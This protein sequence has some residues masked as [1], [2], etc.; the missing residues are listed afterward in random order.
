LAG[1]N[2]KGSVSALLESCF[3]AA[4]FRT[5]RYNSP[6]L[7]EARDAVR[8]DGLP[9]SRE[10]YAN[11]LAQVERVSK[12]RNLDATTFEI[13]TAAF[14]Y[15][16]STAQPPVD[17][18]IVE[19]GMGGARDATNVMPDEIIL[20]SG[21]TSVGLDHTDR[22][23]STIGE[24]AREKASIVVSGAVLVTSPNLHPEATGVARAI[25]NERHAH[26]IQA[27]PSAMLAPQGALSLVP[28]HEPAPAKIR[29]PLE[30]TVAK[31]LD[32]ALGLGGAHQLDNLSLALTLLDVMRHDRRA[33]SIQP[34]LA[35][36]TE[37]HLAAGIA[38]T[39]WEGRCSWLAWRDGNTTVPILA[40]GAH[41]AD[42]AAT[43]R[44]YI[45]GLAL[46]D[47]P[48]TFVLSLSA[49][50]GK[51]PHSVLAPLLRPG[52]RVALV[53]FTTPV[54]GMPWIRPANKADVRA[55]AEALQ[56]S[57]ITDIPGAGPQAVANALRW[58]Q[59]DWNARGPGL[60]VVCG[61]LYLVADA[62]RLIGA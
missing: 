32:T 42:S 16:A 9:P 12:E 5:A 33:A 27:A 18:M 36:L 31:H 11:A 1:T 20:A 6:H 58:A 29:T 21:L 13:A 24:I 45:D 47:R 30:G 49:N 38:N 22:L 57:E 35:Q 44:A 50:P 61:S 10:Q 52:D 56:A 3:R 40:D 34:K 41:N 4:G 60:T 37:A 7:L 26:F 14:F 19:C 43:L 17:V 15:I 8:I 2:G 48:R 28:F 62:Y 51:T 23:G 39:R 54:E 46:P 53:D 55:A 59:S 25:A